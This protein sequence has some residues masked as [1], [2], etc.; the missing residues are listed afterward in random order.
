MSIYNTWQSICDNGF[1]DDN[2]CNLFKRMWL[3]SLTPE[4]V[5][6]VAA[7]R[8]AKQNLKYIN[9]GADAE[10]LLVDMYAI[11]SRIDS[12]CPNLETSEL[13]DALRLEQADQYQR[14]RSETWRQ[15]IILQLD[16]H[17]QQQRQQQ[18]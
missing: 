7:Q 11:Y 2:A 1:I 3:H 14:N 5:G 4:S 12:E 9:S 13:L 8:L 15:N 16:Q 18:R 10:T 6:L 17:F